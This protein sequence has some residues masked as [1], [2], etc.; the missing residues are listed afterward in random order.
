MCKF[1]GGYRLLLFQVLFQQDV[2]ALCKHY[3]L[4]HPKPSGSNMANTDSFQPFVLCFSVMTSPI[5][6]PG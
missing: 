5:L 3:K 6:C 4:S 1:L 2:M